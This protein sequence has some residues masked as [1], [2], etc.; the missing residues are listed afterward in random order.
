MQSSSIVKDLQFFLKGCRQSE[1]YPVSCLRDTK[2]RG[3]EITYMMSR[4]YL[5]HELPQF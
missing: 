3:G 1:P 4:L 5:G 2:T